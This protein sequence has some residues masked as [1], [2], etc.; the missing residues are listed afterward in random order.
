[1]PTDRLSVV[2]RE[3][4]EADK[5][6]SSSLVDRVCIAAVSL[7]SLKGAGLSLMVDGELRG[8][9]GMSE[10]GIALVQ[11][12]QLTLGEG[13]CVDAWINRVPV[14]ESNLAD[15]AVV[16]WPAFA[17]AGVVDAGVLAVFAFPLHLGAIRIGVL[18][19]YRGRSGMLNADEMAYGLV[20]ADMATQVLLALQ[21]GAPADVLHE[22]LAGE[23]SHWAE[24]HQATGMIS[25]QLGVSLDEAF[26]RLR[27]HAFAEGLPLRTVAREI[28][29]RRYCLQDPRD[30]RSRP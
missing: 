16:R 3:I 18:V 22:V 9:A 7:L 2:L 1:M 6:G 10:P 5:D 25:V 12:L 20:L 30:A 15:P 11:E 17:Q 28:V 13:P 29:T 4:M 8:T 23:P 24:V 14:L 19:L 27:A 26:V 21:A